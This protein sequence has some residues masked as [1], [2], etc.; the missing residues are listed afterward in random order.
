MSSWRSGLRTLAAGTIVL[1]C[2][3]FLHAQSQEPKRRTLG[4]GA[5]TSR[6]GLGTRDCTGC[7][8]TFTDKYMGM[9]N[10]HAPVRG[11]KCDDCHLRHGIVAK[12]VLKREGNNLC[13]TCHPKDKLGLNKSQVHT[14][15]KDGRC[16]QCHNPHA[17]QFD[18]LLSADGREVCYAC[19]DK[20]AY[21]QPVVHKVLETE[22]C[23]A[24]HSSHASDQPGLLVKDE[25]ALCLGCHATSTATSPPVVTA[26]SWRAR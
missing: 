19:H 3:G 5:Q 13:V 20:A 1:A 26:S 15:V 25:K 17:S 7:H 8:K 10:V 23:I 24:C 2:L 16:V 4:G 11:N 12:L 6:Q 9:K 22:G 21:T 14:A 18:H